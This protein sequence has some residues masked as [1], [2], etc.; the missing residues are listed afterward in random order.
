VQ[1]TPLAQRRGELVSPASEE[2][3]PGMLV[4]VRL[5]ALWVKQMLTLARSLERESMP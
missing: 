1:L 5:A 2:V 4:Q 3:V